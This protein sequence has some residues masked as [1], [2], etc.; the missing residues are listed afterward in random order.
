MAMRLLVAASAAVLVSA[1][2][3]SDGSACTAKSFAIPSW[4]VQDVKH[5]EGVIS[6]NVW[7]RATNYTAD[8]ACETTET[9]LN[10]CSI[11][12][13]PSSNDTLEASVEISGDPTTF[14]LKQSWTCSDREKSLKFTA[15]GNNSA[16]ADYTSPLLIKG[17][18]TSPVSITPVYPDGPKGHDSAGCSSRSESPT[19]TL[20]SIHY[21]D[22]PA[23][24]EGTVAFKN[25]NVLVTNPANGY[26]AS[27]MPGG[28]F[29]DEPDLAHLMCAGYEF[30]SSSV[31]Q[32]PIVTQASFDPD[33]STF[34]LNQTWFCDD[35]DAAK[36]LQITATGSSTLPLTCTT[37]PGTRNQTNTYCSTASSIP[38]TGQSGLTTTL[39]PYALEDPAPSWV[40][41]PPRGDGCT[42][43]SI[44]AP[45]WQFSAFRLD[46][47]A[48][49]FEIIL[50]AGDIGFQYPIPVYQGAAVEG[51]EEEG[52]YA[53]EVGADGGNGLPLW[54][55][56]C[57]FR[58]EE[59]AE[60]KGGTLVLD[61]DWE[62]RDLDRVHPVKF[63]GVTNTAVNTT[64][65]CETVDGV[66]Q[67]MTTDPGYTWVAPITDV[68]W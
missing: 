18:L 22:E 64:L 27:C 63:S 54:P 39:R 2:A 53:C 50:R 62:C 3:P 61:A 57:R 4:F 30:Q 42:L 31:G 68:T 48:V 66:S 37:T 43:T 8:L 67:C 11:Q 17:S 1:Q 59:G 5:A 28:S 55:Y 21:T 19:W 41:T 58:Y 25:F 36:P 44:F 32:Y 45:R 10:A 34:T 6:F 9:G 52:W 26:Q 51:Q 14:H 60:G 7:N 23:S 24:G 65:E 49:S 29:G 15:V 12:G 46:G 56:Q 38:L 40:S 33:T 13:T 16:A 20:S 47:G 35:V